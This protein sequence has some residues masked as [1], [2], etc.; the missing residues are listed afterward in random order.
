M[1]YAEFIE[2]LADYRIEPWGP[3]RAD[4]H[5]AQVV[6][7][8]ANQ[9]RPR[10]RRAF[11]LEECRLRFAPAFVNRKRQSPQEVCRRIEQFFARYEQR[12]AGV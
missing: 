9:Q 10:H 4:L 8:L 3:T 5:A 12:R 7:T 1:S 2:H 6:C 11:T